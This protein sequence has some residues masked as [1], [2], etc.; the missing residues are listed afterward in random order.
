[1]ETIKNSTP[2]QLSDI[3]FEEIDNIIADLEKLVPSATD[4]Q[5]SSLDEI[6]GICYEPNSDELK[7]ET[8]TVPNDP[9]L[10]KEKDQ[11]E[12]IQNLNLA[13]NLCSEI[14]EHFNESINQIEQ[15]PDD[16]KRKEAI[17]SID[18]LTLKTLSREP[19]PVIRALVCCNQHTPIE[20]LKYIAE[21]SNDYYRLII[22]HN[23]TCNIDLLSRLAEITREEI[24]FQAIIAHPN[25]TPLIISKIELFKQIK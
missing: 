2:K 14:D 4:N 23:P 17:N 7:I 15:W 1:M 11:S 3:D 20:I 10:K 5:I 8:P 22:A 6:N 13:N 16:K 24:V 9:E 18:E 19:S 12:F 25:T 21:K